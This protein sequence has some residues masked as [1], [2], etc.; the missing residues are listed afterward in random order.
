MDNLSG[1]HVLQADD[2]TGNEEPWLSL[3]ED[4]VIPQMIS[5][6]PTITIIHD[7][8]E[9]LPILEGADDVD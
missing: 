5:H 2:D 7:E 3:T 6:I 8:I 1:V 9:V 4:T